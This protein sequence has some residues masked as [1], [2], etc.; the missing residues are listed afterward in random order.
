MQNRATRRPVLHVIKVSG[1]FTMRETSQLT[2]RGALLLGCTGV[3]S[4]KPPFKS[5]ESDFWNRKEASQWSSEE[6]DRLVTASPWAK[7]VKA[8]ATLPGGDINNGSKRPDEPTIP[9][10]GGRIGGMSRPSI[11]IPVAGGRGD[12]VL[13]EVIVRWESAKPVLVALK[14]PL[15][16]VFANHYVIS[17]SGVPSAYATARTS[18][19]SHDDES[20]V[21]RMKSQSYLEA[22]RL[23]PIHADVAQQ[24]PGA[25]TQAFLFGFSNEKL[26]LS[27]DD[28]EV[29]FV[30]Q[31]GKSSI[32]AKFNLKEMMYRDTLAI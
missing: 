9:G 22:K 31:V 4:A 6:I 7:Q 17:V 28:N 25:F 12:K 15:A 21:D 11:R 16:E 27:L 2:R 5:K 30:T 20:A 3:L 29:T 14:T 26:H 19:D 18:N 10:A 1:S 8:S 23:F 13:F 32:R 24:A